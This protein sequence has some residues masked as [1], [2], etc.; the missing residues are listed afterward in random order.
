MKTYTESNLQEHICNYLSMIC[1]RWNFV[2]FSVPNEGIM[3]V[4]K[5]FKVP[6]RSCYAIIAFFKKIGLL[7]GTS[8][9]ILLHNSKAYCLE[10]KLEKYRNTEKHGQSKAQ[11][12][13]EINV[14]KTGVPY[15]IVYG[16]KDVKTALV[17]WGI[18]K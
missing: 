7:S 9:I 16:H 2:Y 13:F 4:L 15:R 1:N 6:D 8:D 18:I 10:V 17:E 3:T 11:I 12:I 14:N 5:M